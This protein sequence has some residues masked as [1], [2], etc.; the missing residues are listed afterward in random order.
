[1]Q[2]S[3]HFLRLCDGCL[4]ECCQIIRIDWRLL[5]TLRFAI[6]NL[7]FAICNLRIANRKLTFEILGATSKAKLD[8]AKPDEAL[9]NLTEQYLAF[10][11]GQAMRDSRYLSMP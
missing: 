11:E 10:A 7:Q 1:M 4:I 9:N 2:V 5:I 6:C 3:G 8:E